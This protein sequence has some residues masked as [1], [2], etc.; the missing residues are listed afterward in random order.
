MEW[1]AFVFG[2]FIGSFLNVCIHRLP[3]STVDRAPALGVPGCGHPIRACDNIPVVSYLML[4]GRCRDCGMRISPRYPLVELLSGGFASMAVLQFG[5]GWEGL[6]MYGL[7][8]ALL[9]I[10]FIDID[11]RIIPD[12]HHAARY[13][14][15]RC[16]EFRPLARQP[17]GVPDRHPGRR[18]QPVARGVGVPDHHQT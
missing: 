11:H 5:L 10:T 13:P 6:L 17:A 7:I 8:A 16:R 2:L 1:V 12:R 9:V 18:R 14:H 4:R 3:L 15:R